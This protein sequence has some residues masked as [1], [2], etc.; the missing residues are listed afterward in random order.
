MLTGLKAL[1]TSGPTYEPLDPVRFIGNYSSGKQ[2]HAI[3]QALADAGVEVWLIHGP[4]SLPTPDNVH[5]I[6]VHTASEMLDACLLHLPVDIAIC[7]AAV[8][9][10]RPKE[11][12]RHKIKKQPNQPIQTMTL[13]LIRNP[14]ILATLGH[15]PTLRPKVVVGFAAETQ[16]V[17][18]HARAKCKSKGCDF[19]I[20]NEIN[21]QHQPFGNQKNQVTYVSTN[22]DEQWPLMNKEDVAFRIIQKINETLDQR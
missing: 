7:A 16:D 18:N 14:D 17:L 6:A 2:G 9:D 3:A 13:E 1:V 21:Q 4:V 22:D 11:Q 10:F 15:H 19:I 20:A 5:A 8:A 12:S